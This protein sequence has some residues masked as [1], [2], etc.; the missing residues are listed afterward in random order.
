MQTLSRLMA[1]LFAAATS[2]G[3]A[4][5]A[6][7]GSVVAQSNDVV[8]VN[9]RRRVKDVQTCPRSTTAKFRG[10]SSAALSL[11]TIR[12]PASVAHQEH[13]LP[14]AFTSAGALLLPPKFR[15]KNI[16]MM[17]SDRGRAR[18]STNWTRR[19]MRWARARIY[20]SKP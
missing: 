4:V 3:R 19:L 20:E 17:R 7:A 18:K 10:T 13:V 6:Q 5:H 12:N 8:I 14:L 9:A 1:S 2:L 11:K 15:R 16:S